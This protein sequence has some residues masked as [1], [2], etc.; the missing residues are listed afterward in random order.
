MRIEAARFRSF[1]QKG[2]ALA[3]SERLVL[4][5]FVLS[6]GSLSETVTVEAA[7]TTI[8]TQSSDRSGLIDSRHLQELSLKGRDYLGTL[9]LLPGILDTASAT[10]EAPGNRALIGLFVNGNRQGTL[11]LALD[12]I[13]TLSLGGGTG[14]F[15]QASIDAVEEVK[16]LQTNYQ[17][18][19][20]R[21]VGGT[22]HTVTRS[23]T[24]EL[25]GGAYYYFRN[26]ALNAND[27]FANYQGLPRSPYRY[28]NPGYF[29]GGPVLFPGSN[30]N[31]S[32]NKLF[33]FFSGDYLVA[34]SRRVCLIRPSRRCRNGAAISRRRWTRTANGS[35]CAIRRRARRSRGI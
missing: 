3:S 24:R 5:P 6:L 1:E 18:E 16:V 25:H 17:A 7:P 29:V 22:I 34:R 26:E 23:G 12:G 35:R 31:R 10:R 19:N 28:N 21:S 2:I 32:R 30:F 33:F 27:F 13:S 20:G 8:E 9:K 4:P 11:N 14:P 15:L